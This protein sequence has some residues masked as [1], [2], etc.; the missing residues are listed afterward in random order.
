MTSRESWKPITEQEWQQRLSEIRALALRRLACVGINVDANETDA[1]P[2]VAS[3]VLERPEGTAL[4]PALRHSKALAEAAIDALGDPRVPYEK[5]ELAGL[6]NVVFDYVM[7]VA[8]AGYLFGVIVGA[9][10]SWAVV[11]GMEPPSATPAMRRKAKK[12][13]RP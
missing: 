11:T 13:G 6:S 1:I 2:G 10:T 4:R 3:L 8:E 5:G 7:D 9:N 12:G